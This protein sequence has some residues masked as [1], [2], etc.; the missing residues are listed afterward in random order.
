MAQRVKVSAVGPACWK[1]RTTIADCP[2]TSVHTTLWHVC[3]HRKTHNKEIINLEIKKLNGSAEKGTCC[4][5]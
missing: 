2:L 3:M 1:E 4:Q 5:T